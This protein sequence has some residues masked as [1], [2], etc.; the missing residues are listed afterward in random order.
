MRIQTV[1]FIL[2]GAFVVSAAGMSLAACSSSG[3]GNPSTGDD[4]G[5]T[6]DGTT[7]DTGNGNGDTGTGTDTGGGDDGGEGGCQGTAPTFHPSDGGTGPYC[8]FS[9][10]G[11]AGNITCAKGQHCCETAADAGTP[12][13]CSDISSACPSA[14]TEW[15]CEDPLD[16]TSGNVCCAITSGPGQDPGCTWYFLHAF[17]GTVCRPADAGCAAGQIV[18]CESDSECPNGQKCQNVK[19]KGASFGFCQ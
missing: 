17:K 9:K 15:Q 2:G 6:H 19:A 3:T 16:C 14:D 5:G 4:G 1:A 8:P 10:T 12:S 18:V 7:G 11:D 13:T